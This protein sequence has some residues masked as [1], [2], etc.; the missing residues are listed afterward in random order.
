[1]WA[2]IGIALLTLVYS[3]L[4]G[5]RGSLRT[6][7]LQFVLFAI[8]LVVVLVALF[9]NPVVEFGDLF[10]KPFN[11]FEPGP[12]LILVALLQVWSYPAHDPVMIDRGFLSDRKTTWLSFMHA[13]WIS[14][15]CII[16]FGGIGIIAGEHAAEGEAYDSHHRAA[17]WRSSDVLL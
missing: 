10:A 1:M 7:V 4:G 16:A 2:I 17:A 5:L 6:D 9:L 13:F 12:I 15:F 14:A 3:M 8:T 11:A